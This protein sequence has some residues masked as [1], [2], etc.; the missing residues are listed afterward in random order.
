MADGRMG[1]WL[2]GFGAHKI[3]FYW[4]CIGFELAFDW[5]VLAFLSVKLALFWRIHNLSK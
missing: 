3:G 5:L 2:I 1:A 4:V